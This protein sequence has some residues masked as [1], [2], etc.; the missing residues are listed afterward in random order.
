MKENGR[1]T[2]GSQGLGGVKLLEC[3]YDF[4]AG[5]GFGELDIHLIC[6]TFGNGIGDLL[7]TTRR[8]GSAYF[9]K[10]G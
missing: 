6:N 1:H 7:G 4:F 9:F 5:E 3:S 2:V 8:D 10:V